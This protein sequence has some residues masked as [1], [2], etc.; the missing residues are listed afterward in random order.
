M[1]VSPPGGQIPTIKRRACGRTL[2]PVGSRLGER[3]EMSLRACTKLLLALAAVLALAVSAAGG[4]SA[5]SGVPLAGT[6]SPQTG[7]FTPSGDN[8]LESPFQG[9]SEEATD[10]YNGIVDRSLSK[11]PGP[12]SSP[13]SG[14]KPSSNPSFVTG[15]EGLNHYQQRYSRG[16]NQFS[17]E[18][19]D[20]GLCVRHRYVVQVTNDVMNLFH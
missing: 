8:A 13:Q 20:Q 9:D 7:D 10:A 18:P 2:R 15:F 16:G 5:A 4:A 1:T 17:L 11:G 14:K 19:P 6:G 3:G 12:G